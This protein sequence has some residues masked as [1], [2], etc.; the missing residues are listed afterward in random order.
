MLEMREIL[1]ILPHRYPFLL[2]DRIIEVE[3]NIRAIDQGEGQAFN[4]GTGRGSTVN[5]V[6]DSLK[7]LTHYRQDAQYQPVRP[8]DVYK[9]SLDCGKARRALGWSPKTKLEEGLR[10]TVEYFRDRRH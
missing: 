9:I 8:G 7:A 10:H 1:T 4:I 6:F 5:Q 2:V 3:A